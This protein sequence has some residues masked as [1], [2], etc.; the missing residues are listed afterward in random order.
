[1]KKERRRNNKK[2]QNIEKYTEKRTKWKIEQKKRKL[3]NEEKWC[4]CA[5]PVPLGLKCACTGAEDGEVF[6]C[7]CNVSPEHYP[8]EVGRVVCCVVVVVVW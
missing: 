6:N 7:A 8:V 4:A 5:G 3:K 1:M 2:R